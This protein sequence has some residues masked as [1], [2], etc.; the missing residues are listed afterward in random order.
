MLDALAD[1]LALAALGLT[2]EAAI[3]YPQWLFA[4]IGHPVTWIGALIAA[5]DRALNRDGA[6]ALLRRLAGV[7]AILVVVSVALVAGLLLQRACLALPFG[8]VPLAVVTSSLYAQRS[9]YSHVRD[10]A[11]A[12]GASLERGRASV[13]MIV[14]RDVSRLDRA[15]VSRAAIESLAENFSDGV[16]GPALATALFGLPGALIYKAVNT[17]DSMIGHRTMRHEAFG[18]ASARLDDLLN[19]PAARLSALLVAS[20]AAMTGGSFRASLS[21]CRRDASAHASP[22]AGWPEAA[23][24]GALGIRLGGPRAYGAHEVDGAWLGSGRAEAA[25]ADI[26]RA[27][28][29]FRCAAATA[30]CGFGGAALLLLSKWAA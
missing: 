10:V 13:A 29:I 6:P 8:I 20:G 22:N 15:G 1:N 27:L 3:G 12:L 28:R 30:I 23:M 9:L 19:L 24:A 14:G 26:R 4:A 21:T 18:W 11:D 7:G 2:I 16:I 17:A 25:P 5:L